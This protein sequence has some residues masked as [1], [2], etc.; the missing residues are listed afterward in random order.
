M[1]VPVF[2]A[3]NLDKDIMITSKESSIPLDTMIIASIIDKN[4]KEYQMIKNSLNQNNLY[5]L[6]L[7]LF[8]NVKNSKITKLDNGIF[9]V[10]MPV[11]TDLEG[12][13]LAI[14]YVTEDGK[15]EEHEVTIKDGYATFQTDHFSIYTLAEK[16]NNILNPKTGDSI[17]LYIILSICS[18]LM[19]TICSICL[20]IKN[21]RTIKNK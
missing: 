6:D 8:S 20:S 18:F 1:S 15:V 17:I 12:K 16:T 14:Y 13:N 2:V 11:P 9:E 10:T 7:T 3:K 4:S 5:S 19:L 21:K